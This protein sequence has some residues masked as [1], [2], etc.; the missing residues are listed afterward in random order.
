M[1]LGYFGPETMLPLG[2][3]IAAVLG[4]FLM[5][6]RQVAFMTR[7][8]FGRMTR[9]FRSTPRSSVAAI[10]PPHGSSIRYDGGA[11]SHAPHAPMTTQDRVFGRLKAR[12]RASP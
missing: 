11:G 3:A 8:A 10:A 1:L 5:F 9:L 4:V 7:R 12:R 2:S 6:G